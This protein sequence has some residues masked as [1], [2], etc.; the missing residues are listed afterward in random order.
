MARHPTHPEGCSEFLRHTPQEQGLFWPTVASMGWTFD[1][2]RRQIAAM[3]CDVF[4]VGLFNPY[5]VGEPIMLPRTWDADRLLRSV[6]WMRLQNRN[7]RNVYVR[8]KGEHNL[9]LVDDL[10]AQAVGAMKQEGFSPALVVRTS[11]GNHQVWLK[12]PM[13]LDRELGT[14]AAR[15]LTD[16]FGG[17]RGAADWRHFG[18]LAGFANRKAKYADPVT[19]L[20]PYVLLL[21][22]DGKVYPEAQRF[23]ARVSADVERKHEERKQARERAGSRSL[24]ARPV[25]LKSIDAFRSD[26]RYGGDGNRIDLAYAIYAFA[27]GLGTAEVSAAILARNLTHKG[28]ERRQQEYVERTIKKAFATIERQVAGRGR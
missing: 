14:A 17:D 23:L 9:S 21:E 26:A 27:H 5:A 10:T 3:D 4:E 25:T 24:T 13:Q 15:A 20:F 6:P 12:H 2:V 1:A 18:R 28:N 7:G 19:G 8:P 22:A 11:P 16:R